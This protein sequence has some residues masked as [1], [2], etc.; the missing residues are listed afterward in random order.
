MTRGTHADLLLSS[1]KLSP[2]TA[3]LL[4]SEVDAIYE[5][6]IERVAAGR[7]LSRDEVDALAQGRVWTGEQAF[8]H[9]LIDG[10]G[11]LREAVAQA[12]QLLDLDPA[13]DIA[14]LPYPPPG[15]FADQLSELLRGVALQ[16]V[17]SVSL[18]GLA[19]RLQDWLAAV[20]TGVPALVPPFVLEI[21]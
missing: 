10:L 8:E 9:G 4:R 3:G 12:K 11:G 21:R 14:L 19:G 20:P 5:L 13:A 16:A 18:P 6:F 1:A 17:P 7:K 15:S 2:E